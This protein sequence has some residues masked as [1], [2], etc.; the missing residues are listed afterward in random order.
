MEPVAPF[1]I[2]RKENPP[3]YHTKFADAPPAT[4]GE[5]LQPA[6]A[7]ALIAAYY[8]ALYDELEKENEPL[9]IIFELDDSIPL[10]FEQ[11]LQMN[12]AAYQ[13]PKNPYTHENCKG[14]IVVTKNELVLKGLNGVQSLG[15]VKNAR[16]I[17]SMEEALENLF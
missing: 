5:T 16:G 4:P 10:T 8:G 12:Q 14:L 13:L 11:Y 17:R 7:M 9:N 15:I 1:I 6:D 2:E 3:R